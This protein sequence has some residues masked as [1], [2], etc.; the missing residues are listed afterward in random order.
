MRNAHPSDAP[1]KLA[2]FAAYRTHSRVCVSHVSTVE[3]KKRMTV[4]GEGQA[5][6]FWLDEDT[7]AWPTRQGST[8]RLYYAARGGIELD[9][10]RVTGADGSVELLVK[11]G[12]ITSGQKALDPYLTGA[13]TFDG[14]DFGA[15]GFA[16]PV[17]AAAL[18]TGQVVVLQR[19]PD[20]R[21]VAFSS[22]QTARILDA[23]Y[24]ESARLRPQGV[25]FVGGVPSFALW[26]PT[27]KSVTLRLYRG[28]ISER[29]TEH[30]M[31]RESDGSWTL[32]GRP[33]WRDKPYLYDVEVYIPVTAVTPGDEAQRGIAGT[34]Q[35]NLVTDPNSVGLTIDSKRSVVLDLADERYMPEVWADTPAPRI[36]GFAERAIVELHVRDFSATDATVPRR[37][38]G[39]YG[40]FGV[41]GS[42]GMAY[43]REL[44]AAGMN[45]VHLLPT[46]DMGS[47]PEDP[48]EQRKAAVPADAAPDSQEQQAAVGKVADVDAFNWGYDPLHY[49]TPEGSYAVKANG[50]T[51]TAEYRQMVGNLHKAGYQVVQDI[52]FNHTYAYGQDAKSVFEKIVPG[53]YHRLGYE[54]QTLTSPCCG[55]FATEHVMAENLMIDSLLTWAR[56]YKIDGF[57]FDLMEFTSVES[58]K[59]IRAALDG[60]TMEEDGVDGKSMYLYGEGWSFGTTANGSRFTPSV[61]GAMNGT[62]IGTFNDRLRD[63]VH[64][65]Q[66]DGKNDTQGFGNGLVT[67]PN[68]IA[69]GD[70]VQLRFFTDVIR[71][72][73]AGN[74]RDYRFTACDGTVRRGSEIYFNGQVV[75]YAS[76]PYESINYVDAHDNETLY[77]LNMWKM[78]ANSTMEDRVRMNTVSLATVTLGQSPAFWHAGTD[79]LRSKSMDRNSYNSGD[80]FNA[81]NW[82]GQ[83]S[84]FGVGLPPERDNRS[85]W[86]AMSPYLANPANKPGAKDI[87]AAHGQ[88]LELLALRRSTPLFTLGEAETIQQKVSFPN[89]GPNATLG[90]L[91]MV[92]DDTVGEDLDPALDGVM[93]V[94][95]ASPRPIVET[96]EGG[97]GK[98]YRLSPIQAHGTDPVVKS[99]VWD[100]ATG[101]V[102]IPG[103]TVAVLTLPSAGA[104]L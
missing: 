38:R 54:G 16:E 62:G 42:A 85:R 100:A 43:L 1:G 97:R 28:P 56:A 37:L 49:T 8:Y 2:V 31:R 34:V 44:A 60:L 30:P 24:A 64:G 5:I 9:G 15:L 32:T 53:Y 52:V 104:R 93:V 92:V 86:Q 7:I 101:T 13:Y 89:A 81:I 103:R 83:E 74:L 45:T 14:E 70:A 88:A 78:P 39:K 26:A 12:G 87:A 69:G 17:N 21:P 3:V 55:E 48:A 25:T 84:N 77:D 67:D 61:Q 23:M 29:Y 65:S 82:T 59:R 94:F 71:V 40:A 75:G 73:L 41:E 90:L 46:Y 80:W 27:A 79:L 98:A 58:M 63:A 66:S 4:I 47:V 99:T 6:G 72:G 76:Q 95:N 19:G 18:L 33:T 11:D 36:G 35:H 91:V 10:E 51:R 68:G 22:L 96:I 102:T 50:G 20:G 57:R